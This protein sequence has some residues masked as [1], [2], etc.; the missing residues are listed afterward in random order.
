MADDVQRT[1][2]RI[3][4]KVDSLLEKQDE[5]KARLDNHGQRIGKIE[6]WQSWTL[7]ACAAIGVVAGLLVTVLQHG[8]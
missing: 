1:L 8:R 7:G 5:H 3:E 4:S 2:G 6:R